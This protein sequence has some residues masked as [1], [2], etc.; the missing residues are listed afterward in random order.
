LANRPIQT[1]EDVEH[2]FAQPSFYAEFAPLED[3]SNFVDSIYVLKDRGRLTASRV[4]FASPL[5]EIAAL[6]FPELRILGGHIGARLATR[7]CDVSK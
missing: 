7:S 3:H 5:R 6:E 2:L 1:A 4:A